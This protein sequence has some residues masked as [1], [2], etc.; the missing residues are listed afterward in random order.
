MKRFW[1]NVRYAWLMRRELN[2]TKF[3]YPWRMCWMGATCWSVE[4]TIEFSP[5][6]ALEAELEAWSW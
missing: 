1:W 4:D 2:N 3:G 6:E 5:A